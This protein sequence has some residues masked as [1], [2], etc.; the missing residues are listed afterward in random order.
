MIFSAEIINELNKAVDVVCMAWTQLC[1]KKL[2]VIESRGSCLLRPQSF[3]K[4]CYTQTAT[5][6]T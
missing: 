3:P 2:V 4:R 6:C 1:S 5:E